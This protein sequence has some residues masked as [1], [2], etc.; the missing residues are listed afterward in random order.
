MLGVLGVHDDADREIRV[1]PRNFYVIR[2]GL[3][4]V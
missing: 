2:A 4:G 3:I 1:D